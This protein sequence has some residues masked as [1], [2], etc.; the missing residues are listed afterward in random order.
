MGRLPH[1]QIPRRPEDRRADRTAAGPAAARVGR[2]A[3]VPSA[4]AVANAI[5]DATGVRFRELPFTPERILK[6][7]RGEEPAAPI[8]RFTLAGG[9]RHLDTDGKIR[10]AGRHA[11]PR[12]ASQHFAQPWSASEPPCCRGARSRRSRIDLIGLFRRDDCPRPA[13]AALGGA[14]CVTPRRTASSVP[15]AGPL[16]TPFRHHPLDQHYAMLRQASAHGPIT[17]ERSMR[18]GIHRD[19]RHLYPAFPYH[20]FAKTTV[21]P[22][23]GALR[24]SDGAGAGARR[25][26]P[27]KHA[28]L[29]AQFAAL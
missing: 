16:E 2:S 12:P 22:T 9:S 28:R 1:H 27:D 4:F 26:A 7:L 10:F 3:S 17:F 24:L 6:G 29:P 23:C 5:F 18:E 19:G 15:A 20:H 14:R 13:A 25:D 8:T 21:T 11:C